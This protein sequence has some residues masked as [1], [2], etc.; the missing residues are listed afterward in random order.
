MHSFLWPRWYISDNFITY[1]T[2]LQLKFIK[3]VMIVYYKT[4][5]KFRCQYLSLF[6][7]NKISH[8]MPMF[9]GMYFFKYFIFTFLYFFFFLFFKE[10]ETAMMVFQIEHVIITHSIVRDVE[11]ISWIKQPERHSHIGLVGW[12]TEKKTKQTSHRLGI[13]CDVSCKNFVKLQGWFKKEKKKKEKMKSFKMVKSTK[14]FGN[15]AFAKWF[16]LLNLSVVL[17]CIAMASNEA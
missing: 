2:F 17:S 12:E 6:F 7:L 13:Y 1:L 15:Q 5:P 9:S 10:R 11:Y 14:S 16:V 4:V 3:F 8:A